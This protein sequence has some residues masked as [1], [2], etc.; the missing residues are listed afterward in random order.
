LLYDTV[1]Y[2]ESGS[3]LCIAVITTWKTQQ[4]RKKDLCYR[5]RSRGRGFRRR[6][7]CRWQWNIGVGRFH[8]VLRLS[9]DAVHWSRPRSSSASSSGRS[10]RRFGTGRRT[11]PVHNRGGSGGWRWRVRA[12]PTWTWWASRSAE[13]VPRQLPWR[14]EG[15]SRLYHCEGS[16]LFRETSSDSASTAPP[17][18]ALPLLLPRC[19]STWPGSL[20]R[21]RRRRRLPSRW[22]CDRTTAETGCWGRRRWWTTSPALLFHVSELWFSWFHFKRSSESVMIKGKLRKKEFMIINKK[23]GTKIEEHKGNSELVKIGLH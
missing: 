17:R 13:R 20:L 12:S 22:H 2:E 1:K 5:K 23:K 3:I 15:P 11:N 9:V 16:C 10:P 8:G 21:R 18:S 4:M 6:D 14:S 7:F 19:R